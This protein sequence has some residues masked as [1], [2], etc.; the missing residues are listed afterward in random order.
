MRFARFVRFLACPTLTLSL[1]VPAKATGP[2]AYADEVFVDITLNDGIQTDFPSRGHTL[3]ATFA[4]APDAAASAL[5]L[6]G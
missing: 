6:P 4:Q 3:D 2:G 5:T 1:L